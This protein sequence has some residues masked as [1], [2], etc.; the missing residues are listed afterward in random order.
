MGSD[1]TNGSKAAPT[2]SS[3]ELGVQPYYSDT[4]LSRYFDTVNTMDV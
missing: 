4:V 3:P 1:R 2:E